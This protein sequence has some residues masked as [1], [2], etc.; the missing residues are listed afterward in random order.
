MELCLFLKK[1]LVTSSYFLHPVDKKIFLL[2]GEKHSSTLSLPK[3]IKTEMV[4]KI[5]EFILDN[6]AVL[7]VETDLESLSLQELCNKDGCKIGVEKFSPYIPI[8]LTQQ[9]KQYSRIVDFD[10]KAAISTIFRSS[11]KDF[12]QLILRSQTKTILGIV[13]SFFVQPCNL[14]LLQN[15]DSFDKEETTKVL[16]NLCTTFQS[17]VNSESETPPIKLITLLLYEIP[18]QIVNLNLNRMVTYNKNKINII[19]GGDYHISSVR[20]LLLSTGFTEIEQK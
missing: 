11:L 2:F 7:F 13:D 5:V 8:L 16:S 3:K 4:E 19:Y 6:S 17:L 15:M 9:L 18:A 20:K 14:F 12:E 10:I 1:Y